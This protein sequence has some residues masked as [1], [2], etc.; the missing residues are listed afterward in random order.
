MVTKPSLL[1]ERMIKNNIEE[2]NMQKINKTD[3]ITLQILKTEH[4][5]LTLQEIAEKAGETPEKI[6]KSLWKIFELPNTNLN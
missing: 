1:N 2:K 3:R 6:K 5:E 4:K